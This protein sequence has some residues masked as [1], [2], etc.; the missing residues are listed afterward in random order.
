MRKRNQVFERSFPFLPSPRVIRHFSI[1]TRFL[2]LPLSLSL[3][4]TYLSISRSLVRSL[5]ILEIS[6]EPFSFRIERCNHFL[7]MDLKIQWNLFDVSR[8]FD[9]IF[10]SSI[11]FF[12]LFFFQRIIRLESENVWFLKIHTFSRFI[13]GSIGSARV[14]IFGKLLINFY[15]GKIVNNFDKIILQS[16]L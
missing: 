7:T 10:F 12:F 6:N 14:A 4:L 9:S 5:A 15:R 3:S 16:R 8:H 13:L 2:S 11:N 1:W